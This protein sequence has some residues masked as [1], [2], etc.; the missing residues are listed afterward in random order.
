MTADAWGELPDEVRYFHEQ[1]W[2][3]ERRREDDRTD[4]IEASFDHG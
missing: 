1:A 3:E 2:Q 4:D